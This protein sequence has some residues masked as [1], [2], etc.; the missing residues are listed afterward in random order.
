MSE[1]GSQYLLFELEGSVY[2]LLSACIWGGALAVSAMGIKNG[3]DPEDLIFLSALTA[4][5]LMLPWLAL[6]NYFSIVGFWRALL[7]M[8]LSGPLFLWLTLHGLRQTPLLHAAVVEAAVLLLGCLVWS[9]FRRD[10]DSGP[11]KFGAVILLLGLVFMSG[12]GVSDLATLK[13]VGGDELVLVVAGLLWVC[14]LILLERWQVDPTAATVVVCVLSALVYCP[15]YVWLHGPL[16]FL[17]HESSVIY[18]QLLVQGLLAGILG[19]YSFAKSVRYLGSSR[20]AI[21]PSMAPVVSMILCV[22]MFH[23]KPDL[24]QWL[25]FTAV[26]AGVLL[27]LYREYS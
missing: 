2:G 18:W 24:T 1:Y 17:L 6:S 4:G 25:G 21:F 5:T 26:S 27:S 8:L 23:Q 12:L 3:L 22:L 13:G 16:H 14:Q 10:V 20:A 15:L 19:F 9:Y 11:D 7:L